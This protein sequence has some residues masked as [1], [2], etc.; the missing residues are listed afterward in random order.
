MRALNSI[1]VL[2]IACESWPLSNPNG[3]T[4]STVHDQ[5][6][7]FSST[8]KADI[9]ISARWLAYRAGTGHKVGRSRPRARG[10]RSKM[11]RHELNLRHLRLMLAVA[12]TGSVTKAAQMCNISQPAVTQA[13]KK[14][15]AH[16]GVPL[17]DR[18]L[19]GVFVNGTGRILA[20]RVERAM[21]LLDAAAGTLGT[22]PRL[23]ASTA[24][25]KALVEVA[26]AENFSIAARNMGIAQPTIHRAITQ[27]EEEVG[28]SLF[29]RTQ[30]GS[31]PTRS[32]QLLAQAAQLAFAELAQAEM[33]IAEAVGRGTLSITIGGMPLSRSYV[34]PGTIAAFQAR[35]A[36]VHFRIVEGP[37]DTLLAGL[38]R[39]E[40]DLLFGALRS[41]APV[42]D[43]IE[44]HLFNDEL[45][46]VSGPNHP[47]TR[48]GAPDFSQALAFPWV[49]AI[50]GT[51]AR[52]QFDAH[53]L[54]MGAMLPA[55]LVE[56]SSMILMR[57]LLHKGPYLG[58]VSRLQAESE[59]GNGLMIPLP[60]AIE[61]SRR[62][63]GL[64]T[65][66]NWKPTPMQD[67][68]LNL[69]RAE[70]KSR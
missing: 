19:N 7:L 27:L 57:E 29:Q 34:L 43:V 6:D 25:L 22:A 51:P 17:F 48:D 54:K 63:I 50:P 12:Q 46:I 59:I 53:I 45:V 52:D 10:A 9:E 23:T 42:D 68:F 24:R 15:E 47:L 67:E 32:G 8:R 64:T 13:L 26:H 5:A 40:I 11:V 39:A 18:N 37:Y 4:A 49:V 16:F 58:A 31:I 30:F 60:L 44:E 28:R 3:R 36:D 62:A 55:T 38:R 35:H 20:S 65:R 70:F 61:E 2:K 1:L 66:A 33:E 41:P 21:G 14:L 56:T 69:I